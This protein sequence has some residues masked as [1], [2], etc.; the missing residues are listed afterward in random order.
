[1]PDRIT[2]NEALVSTD[3]DRLIR[4]IAEKK[5]MEL[6]ELE[7]LT[8]MDRRA[9]DKW[10]RVLEDEGY[11]SIIYGL[12]GTNVLWLGEDDYR[13]ADKDVDAALSGLD[14]RQHEAYDE[15]FS[16]ISKSGS[17]GESERRLG[18]YLRSKRQEKEY[19]YSGKDIK[20]SILGKL[21]TGKGADVRPVAN[22]Q[23]EVP[24][25]PEA[26]EPERMESEVETKRRDF[27]VVAH[28]MLTERAK[29]E[30][31]AV[32]VEVRKPSKMTGDSAK[33]KEL[34]NAYLN[35]MNKEKANLEKLKAEKERIYRE[36]YL[37]LESKVEADIASITERILEK[38]GRVLALKERVL[39]LP[40][41]V[42]EVE[43]VQKMIVQLETDGHEVLR[44]ARED[45][46]KFMQEVAASREELE[47]RMEG[48][49]SSI[50]AEK[51][52]VAEL[53]RLSGD[54]ESR[55][56]D[57]RKAASGTREQIEELNSAMKELLVDLDEAVEMKAEIAGMVEAVK[58][59]VESKET[60]L[61]SVESQ[62]ADIAK[63][64]KW[65]REY[66]RDYESKIDGITSYVR[67]GEEE[68]SAL[69][70]S[71]EAAYIKKYL[72]ELDSMTANYDSELNKAT[73]EERD[74]ESRIADSK[75]RLGE[76]VRDSKE[77][78]TKLRTDTAGIPDFEAVRQEAQN[79]LGTVAQVLAEK[80]AEREMLGEDIQKARIGRV[81]AL[82]RASSAR[83]SNRPIRRPIRKG[84]S[85]RFKGKKRK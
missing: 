28:E 56:A 32:H 15:V 26:P 33:A 52:R 1:M 83:P 62:L 63:V 47:A 27:Q 79:K 41:K 60:E 21:D 80:E 17:P 82:P 49:R 35:E 13:H 66:V 65:V 69:Q 75:R 46:D 48:A 57:L 16:E 7:R 11:I 38:E 64:E 58:G 12:R 4:I 84:S 34:V 37:A 20:N 43:K 8:G 85:G 44:N 36:R 61:D 59:S 78:I 10:V 2:V 70:E 45:V 53:K 54:V 23:P 73:G 5:R 68:L 72:H 81:S 18:D 3:V 24:Q 22:A 50:D 30:E 9:V 31:A 40:D 6:A 67:A 19:G 77:M 42:E 76:L 14:T 55:V 25:G 29:P 71:A 51:E 39:E 74:V